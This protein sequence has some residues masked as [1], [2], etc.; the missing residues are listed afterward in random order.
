MLHNPT[1][2]PPDRPG[3]ANAAVVEQEPFPTAVAHGN[4]DLRRDRLVT[5]VVRGWK[6][7]AYLLLAGLL[8]V[9][10]ALGVI[11]PGLPATPFLLLTSYFLIRSSPRLNAALLGSRLFGPIL[12]DW[13]VHGGVRPDVKIKAV[14]AVAL[15]VG[16]TIAL[17]GRS[18]GPSAAVV[19]LAVVGVAVILN[20]PEANKP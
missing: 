18:P 8:F 10:G 2:Q 14:V 4:A 1:T 9:L 13:Q 6:R 16:I 11:L 3:P 19:L 15:A 7:A 5:K 20:L 12:T 17:T